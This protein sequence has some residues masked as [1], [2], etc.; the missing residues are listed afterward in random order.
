[1]FVDEEHNSN[2][3]VE[4]NTDFWNGFGKI[5][6]YRIL[7]RYMNMYSA[8]YVRK[9][10]R[11]E[12]IE[13]SV[14][15]RPGVTGYTKSGNTRTKSSTSTSKALPTVT[16][17]INDPLPKSFTHH[18][19]KAHAYKGHEV[20]KHFTHKELKFIFQGYAVPYPKNKK[21]QNC[22]ILTDILK[23]SG[24]A[25]PYPAKLSQEMFDSIAKNASQEQ[26]NEPNELHGQQNDHTVTTT[27]VEEKHTTTTD[28]NG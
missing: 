3:N 12:K 11:D 8:E 9:L 13:K 17:I 20:F 6:H 21:E 27:E 28:K 15:L 16:E 10:K 7:H 4:S 2:G 14:A 25:M 18:S 1:V 26:N 22:I 23:K 19:M 5:L 24:D